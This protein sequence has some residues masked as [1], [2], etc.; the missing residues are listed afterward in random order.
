MPSDS[1]GNGRSITAPVGLAN[2]AMEYKG[3][4]LDQRKILSPLDGKA[5]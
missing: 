4:A 5:K 3:D 2:S 1:P